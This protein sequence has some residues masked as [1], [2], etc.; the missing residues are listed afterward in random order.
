MTDGSCDAREPKHVA[1]LHKIERLAKTIEDVGKLADRV[2]GSPPAEIEKKS[3][4][5]PTPTLAEFL[6]TQSDRLENLTNLLRENID[7]LDQS[8]F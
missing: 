1:M 3:E 2:C 4:I 7:R 5:E 8:L 6:I